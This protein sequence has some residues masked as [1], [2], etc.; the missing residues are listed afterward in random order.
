MSID[1][2]NVEQAIK[3][4][5]QGKMLILV[6]DESRENEGDLIIAAEHIT[7]E[8]VNFMVTHARGLICLPMSEEL[9]DKLKLPMMVSNNT[10]PY[11]TA[12]TVSIESKHGV[13][14]GIS[15]EDRAKTIKTAISPSVS[16]N[17]IVTPGHIFPLKAKKHGVFAR[18]GQTEGSVDSHHQR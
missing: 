15:A 16:P 11:E 12:F 7:S 3:E 13:S 10:S 17:D 14:T 5:Q 18:R 8:V 1:F 9:I 4:Y 2:S 6:D